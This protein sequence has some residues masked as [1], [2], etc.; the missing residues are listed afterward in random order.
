MVEGHEYKRD[1]RDATEA[2]SDVVVGG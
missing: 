1:V 2:E